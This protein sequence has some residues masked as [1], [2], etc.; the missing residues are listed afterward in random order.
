MTFELDHLFIWTDPGAPAAQKLIDFGLAEGSPNVH[1]GQ[2]TANRRFFFHNAML[3]LLWVHD[4]AEA[5]NALTA[6]TTLGDRFL[7]RNQTASRFGLCLRRTGV[8]ANA[9]PFAGWDYRPDYLPEHLSV[10]VADNAMRL[11]EPFLFFLSFGGRPDAKPIAQ[12]PPME[13]P[14][15]VREISRIR[16]CLPDNGMR[17]PALQSAAAVEG[18]EIETAASQ[19]LDITFDRG[20]QNRSVSFAP[21]LP[22]SFHY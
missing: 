10:W 3:E 8:E 18:I 16:L 14:A 6:P 1:P 17:S 4:L 20:Q 9:L 15:G 13:H 22:L 2:G 12:Q 7:Q 5:Q 21:E 11:S 19:C